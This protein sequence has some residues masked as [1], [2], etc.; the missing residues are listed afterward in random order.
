ME[1][2]VKLENYQYDPKDEAQSEQRQQTDGSGSAKAEAI[3]LRAKV[4]ATV[5]VVMLK[6]FCL[7][8]CSTAKAQ[9][10]RRVVSGS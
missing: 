3:W 6:A 10:T 9:L 4:M 2:E 7:L 8:I 5:S 1:Q